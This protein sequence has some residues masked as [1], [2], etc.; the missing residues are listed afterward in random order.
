MLYRESGNTEA[1]VNRALENVC[2]T[3]RY[4]IS[5]Y[6]SERMVSVC[7]FMISM[8]TLL[9]LLSNFGFMTPK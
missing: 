1:R 7:E 6:N 4:S 2:E 9:Y 3:E 5:E 8:Y